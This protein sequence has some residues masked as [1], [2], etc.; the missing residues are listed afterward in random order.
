MLKLAAH[1]LVVSLYISI[2]SFGMGNQ[3]IPRDSVSSDT[4]LFIKK[5]KGGITMGARVGSSSYLYISPF[6]GYERKNW[7]YGFGISFSQYIQ[8]YPYFKEERIGIRALTRYQVIDYLFLSAEYDGQKNNV[9]TKNG[10][11][12]KWTN[13]LFMGVGICIPVT[14]IT[15]FNFEF[16]YHLNYEPGQSPYGFRQLIGRIGL[17]F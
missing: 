11:H 9:V 1:F 7:F 14:D 2:S 13:N 3:N 5:L 10:Y 15:T 6:V 17:L 8:N 12:K 16:L 4:S